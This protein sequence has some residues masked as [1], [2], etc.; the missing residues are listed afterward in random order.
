MMSR[1]RGI[2]LTQ[3]MAPLVVEEV[4]E[5]KSQQGT[6]GQKINLLSNYFRVRTCPEW[7]LFQYQVDFYPVEDDIRAR[8]GLIRSQKEALKSSFIFDGSRMLYTPNKL[9][10]GEEPGITKLVGRNRKD[11]GDVLITLRYMDKTKY[12]DP[13]YM[14]FYSKFK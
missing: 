4:K 12:T 5:E 6:S 13:V 8:K 11:D 3:N 10:S 14:T 2:N 7:N 9:D 1:F